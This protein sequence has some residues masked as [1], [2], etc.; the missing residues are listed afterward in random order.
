MKR[1]TA[2][3]VVIVAAL[4]VLMVVLFVVVGWILNGDL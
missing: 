1:S 4:F 3:N 2:A